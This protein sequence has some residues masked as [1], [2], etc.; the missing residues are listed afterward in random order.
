MGQSNEMYVPQPDFDRLEQKVDDGFKEMR[1][2]HGRLEE[3]QA[4][5]RSNQNRMERD[6]ME[7]RREQSHH[8]ELLRE[9]KQ[10]DVETRHMVQQIL[11]VVNDMNQKIT[12]IDKKIN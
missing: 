9:L 6:M 8:S 4:A 10:E 3:G 1:M 5:L 12:A 2:K 11:E 7:L